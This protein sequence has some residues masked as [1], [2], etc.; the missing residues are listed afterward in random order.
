MRC[1]S[2]GGPC[3]SDV[4]AHRDHPDGIEG[5]AVG[6]GRITRGNNPMCAARTPQANRIDGSKYQHGSEVPPQPREQRNEWD[7]RRR[8]LRFGCSRGC[9]LEHGFGMPMC[10]VFGYNAG[11]EKASVRILRVSPPAPD[12][13]TE[14][15]WD[16]KKRVVTH[17]LPAGS[18][19]P[20]A[21]SGGRG[22]A[23]QTRSAGSRCRGPAKRGDERDRRYCGGGGQTVQLGGMSCVVRS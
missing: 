18:G 21:R 20:V 7:G 6:N 11:F 19:T 17:S 4:V 23:P 13:M 9:A 14:T 2:I 15:R 22:T 5:T 8:F 3:G 16:Q 12:R 10:S 1:A